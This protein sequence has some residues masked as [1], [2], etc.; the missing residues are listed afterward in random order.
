MKYSISEEFHSL[1]GEGLY[2]GT[3]MKFVRL[4]YCDVGCPWCDTDYTPNY[5][6]YASELVEDLSEHHLCITGGEPLQQDLEELLYAAWDRDRMTHIET[7][8]TIYIPK[9]MAENGDKGWITISPK[10]DCLLENLGR[11]NEI[12]LVV[13]PPGIDPVLDHLWGLLKDYSEPNVLM[14]LQPLNNVFT[15]NDENVQYAVDLVKQFPHWRLSM[16]MHKPLGLR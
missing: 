11:A 5:T 14:Y 7:S 1:Q 16:Q 12:K 3:P 6:K 10:K 2:T 13:A 15:W 4:A 8:G 9:W